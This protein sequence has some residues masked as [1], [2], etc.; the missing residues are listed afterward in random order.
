M[1]TGLLESSGSESTKL[2]T[3]G[4]GGPL[5]SEMHTSSAASSE[6]GIEIVVLSLQEVVFGYRWFTKAKI[7]KMISIHHYN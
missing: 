7:Y 5:I 6:K 2:I 3:T 4:F 1:L